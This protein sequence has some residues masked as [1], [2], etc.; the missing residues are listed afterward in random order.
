MKMTD[1]SKGK[2]YR[3]VCN[4]T[5][6]V[7]IGSTTQE[8]ER[9]L[10]GHIHSAVISMQCSSDTIIKRGDYKIELLENY[11][12]NSKEAL[13]WKEREWYDKTDCINR[14]SPIQS[15]TEKLKYMNEWHHLH[16]DEKNRIKRLKIKCECGK[17]FN[18]GDIVRHKKS[19]RHLDYISTTTIDAASSPQT[20]EVDPP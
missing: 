6:E 8:L 4:V 18:R 2:I 7:Y 16:K 14:F 19:K 12:C 10:Y 17:E 1:Y 13:L 5:G 20:Q 11:P 3:I 15:R 9:R